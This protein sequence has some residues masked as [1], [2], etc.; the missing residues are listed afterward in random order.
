M[1]TDGVKIALIAVVPSTIGAIGGTIGAIVSLST[2]YKVTE[3]HTQI[4]SRM[5]QLLLA[6]SSAGEMRG[7][8]AERIARHARDASE[9][10]GVK[11]ELDRDK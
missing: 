3:V 6:T 8:A 11:R 9:A 1:M 7:A 2:R 10:I 4:N 5:D